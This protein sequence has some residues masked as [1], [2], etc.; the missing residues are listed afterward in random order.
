[1]AVK[2]SVMAA[3]LDANGAF[4]SGG[5]ISRLL[6]VSRNAVWKA[7]KALEDEGCDVESVTG[8]GYR[9]IA[10]D[11]LSQDAI[12]RHLNTAGLCINVH[13]EV[14]STNRLAKEAA[15]QG[16]PEGTVIVAHAQTAGRGRLG[17]TFCSPPDTG[18]YMSIVLRPTLPAEKALSVTTAAAVAVA[19]AIER[20]SPRQA[21]IKWVNDVF[22][23]DK[24]VCGILTEASLDTETGG[25]SYAVLGIGINV[26]DPKDG[27]PAD[28]RDIAAS[29][30]GEGGG[31]RAALA[32]AVLDE[33]FS[34]YARL[35][36][37]AFV[38]EYRERS[39]MP[40]HQVIVRKPQGDRAATALEVDAQCRLRVRYDDGEEDT[41]SSGDVSIRLSNKK[42]AV[43]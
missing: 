24:K 27:F 36:E 19:R 42:T 11:R 34:L 12:C 8:K 23:D 16:A 33:F 2:D 26:R 20:V 17:R 6:G 43:E 21:R 10:G 30:F 29:V 1:M 40:G 9:L 28:L 3:L 32:A 37:E 31:D 25:L 15:E 41:L 35:D 13:G 5:E 39:L 38:A 18:L 7:I 4:V 22:C 14:T